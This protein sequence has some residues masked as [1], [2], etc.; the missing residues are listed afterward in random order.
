MS[1]RDDFGSDAGRPGGRGG[2][3]GG[4]ANGGVGGGRGGGGGGGGAGRNGGYGSQTGLMTGNKMYGN[5]AFG[6]PGGRALNPGAWGIRPQPAVQQ[7]SLNRPAVPGALS[8]VPV[9]ASYP[10]V[11]SPVYPPAYNPNVFY[12]PYVNQLSNFVQHMNNQYGWGNA[13]PGP[14]PLDPNDLSNFANPNGK[15][16][17]AVGMQGGLGALG[18]TTGRDPNHGSP[19]NGGGGGW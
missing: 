16:L 14:S 2:S 15:P 17:N 18:Y 12:Q 1:A 10:A 19:F 8:P 9:P 11:P 6:R 13:V 3:N 7:S 5:S 4:L